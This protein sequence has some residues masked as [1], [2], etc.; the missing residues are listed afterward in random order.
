MKTSEDNIRGVG[1]QWRT[2]FTI[3]W[4][5]NGR[6]QQL[7]RSTESI[8]EQR[9]KV[10]GLLFLWVNNWG[11]GIGSSSS[12][13]ASAEKK[14]TDDTNCLSHIQTAPTPWTLQTQHWSLCFLSRAPTGSRRPFKWVK[15]NE[16][17]APL[18]NF[19]FCK[20]CF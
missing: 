2:F 13:S 16:S 4:M 19:S 20:T 15:N 6:K 14:T 18:H 5:F 1:E 3:L 10:T 8:V 11:S 9:Q 12:A 17:K 7:V